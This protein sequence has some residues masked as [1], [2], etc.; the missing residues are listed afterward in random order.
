VFKQFKDA[1]KAASTAKIIE[2]SQIKVV[3][4][5][6]STQEEEKPIF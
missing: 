5:V 4:E 6:R 2:D 3:E 1:I